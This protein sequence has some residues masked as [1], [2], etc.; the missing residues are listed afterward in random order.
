M[1]T[2]TGL[3]VEIDTNL[4]VPAME[5]PNNYR[6]LE[7]N[8]WL[9]MFMELAMCLAKHGFSNE[10]YALCDAAKDCIIWVHSKEDTFL[11]HLCFCSK[12]ILVRH[13]IF[14]F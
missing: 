5:I 1:L 4:P 14:D 12:Y 6:G 8:V 7:F 3:N 13:G 9:D 11:I 10:A 2:E